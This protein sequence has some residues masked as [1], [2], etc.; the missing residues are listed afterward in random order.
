MS[1]MD[2]GK[3]PLWEWLAIVAGGAIIGQLSLAAL[4][5]LLETIFE[6]DPLEPGT[7]RTWLGC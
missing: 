2:P 6:P 1:S 5:I 3:R 7:A 4:A